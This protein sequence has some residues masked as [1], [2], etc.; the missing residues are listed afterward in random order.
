MIV[1]KKALYALANYYDSCEQGYQNRK[2]RM[3]LYDMFVP[4][5]DEAFDE[6]VVKGNLL[7]MEIYF[8]HHLF[9]GLSN[10]VYEH[11]ID[12]KCVAK[13]LRYIAKHSK[14][15]PLKRLHYV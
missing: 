2:D 9:E 12:D 10:S 4:C 7:H 8:K 11:H 13:L 14:F 1:N 5:I 3:L 6:K 15:P